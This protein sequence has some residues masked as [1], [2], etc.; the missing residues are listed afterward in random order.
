MD[1]DVMMFAENGFLGSTNHLALCSRSSEFS[2]RLILNYR[3]T[4]VYSTP[5]CR[6]CTLKLKRRGKC[7]LNNSSE[8]FHRSNPGVGEEES[9]MREALEISLEFMKRELS[10]V[11]E[12]RRTSKRKS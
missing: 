9:F 11:D 10:A 5:A 3:I 6:V 2:M 12:S 4:S 8:L 1:Y 7:L